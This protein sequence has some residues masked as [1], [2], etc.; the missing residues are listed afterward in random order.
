MQTL[1]CM[2]ADHQNILQGQKLSFEVT[3]PH[4]GSV[5]KAGYIYVLGSPAGKPVFEVTKP[6]DG[7]L[8][9]KACYV[10]VL[11]SPTGNPG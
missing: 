11:D 7:P 1:K 6:C 5:P 8:P 10:Y 9:K 2:Y 4:D 3:N